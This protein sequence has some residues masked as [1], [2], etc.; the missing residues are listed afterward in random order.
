[1]APLRRVLKWPVIA[2]ENVFVLPGVPEHFRRKFEAIRERFR[3]HPFHIRSIYTREDEFD[4]APR[5][6][7][8]ASGHPNVEIGSYPNFGHDDYKVKV[9]IESKEALAVERA[10]SDLLE[11]LD[12]GELVRTE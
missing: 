6:S 8:L 10:L 12:R 5:L 3:A 9:T 7:R 4:I 2:T 11:L 1:M